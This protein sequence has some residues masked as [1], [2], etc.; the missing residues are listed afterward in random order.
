L[1]AKAEVKKPRAQR[2]QPKHTFLSLGWSGK[3]KSGGNRR[4]PQASYQNTNE[5]SKTDHRTWGA[6]GPWE[7][8]GN[9]EKDQYIKGLSRRLPPTDWDA[10]LKTTTKKGVRNHL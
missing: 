1:E 5:E 3:P 4:R 7:G 8:G 10:L 6:D 9:K 2:A